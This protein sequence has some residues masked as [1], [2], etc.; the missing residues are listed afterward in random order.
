[1]K[2]LDTHEDKEHIEMLSKVTSALARSKKEGTN[3]LNL[4]QGKQCNM[5]QL[6]NMMDELVL[7]L[8][9]KLFNQ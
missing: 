3:Q 2:Q 6:C 9:S 5:Q 7:K 8:E 1:M 4:I